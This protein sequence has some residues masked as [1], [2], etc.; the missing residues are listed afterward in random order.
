[1]NA[2]KDITVTT[3]PLIPADQAA[4]STVEKPNNQGDIWRRRP[5]L[6]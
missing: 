6:P 2:A 3:M 1:M 4:A 5:G